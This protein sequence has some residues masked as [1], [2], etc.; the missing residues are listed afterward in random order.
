VKKISIIPNGPWCYH[1]SPA[2]L[3]GREV[4]RSCLPGR[5]LQLGRSRPREEQAVPALTAE[6]VLGDALNVHVGEQLLVHGGEV[7]AE[8]IA[9]ASPPLASPNAG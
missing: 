1:L 6:Q 7:R 5:R 9:D 4:I 3:G 2:D 8:A